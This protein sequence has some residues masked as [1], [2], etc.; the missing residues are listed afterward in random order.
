MHLKAFV[1]VVVA[2]A[3]VAVKEDAYLLILC[4]DCEG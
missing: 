2:Y 1:T 4:K 3:S